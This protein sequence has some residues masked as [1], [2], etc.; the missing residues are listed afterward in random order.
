MTHNTMA[1]RQQEKQR[2]TIQWIKDNR[3][4]MTDNT[5]A[6]GQQDKQ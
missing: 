5:M 3:K 1:K 6:K 4:N 2:Q